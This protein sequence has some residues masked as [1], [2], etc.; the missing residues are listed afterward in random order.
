MRYIA[1]MMLLFGILTA[2]DYQGAML[3]LMTPVNGI[4][5]GTF[6]VVVNHRF[7]G[8]AFEDEPLVTFFGMD[9]G[10]NVSLGLRYFPLDHAYVSYEKGISARSHTIEIGWVESVLEPARVECNAGYHT[11][12]TGL[13]DN[14]EW[15]GGMTITLGVSAMLV[16][17]RI[18]PVIN[19]AYDGYL[20]EG[21]PGFGLE[22]NVMDN[23]S[24]WGEFFIAADDA[25][26]NDCLSFGTRY[27]TWGHQFLLALTN[28]PWIGPQGQIMGAMDGDLKVGFQIRRMF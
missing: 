20:E 24:L 10:A 22:F 14:A 11:F 26:E 23:M 6:E 25:A 4:D 15:D 27:S 16:Q 28:S 3:N 17:N 21:A 18:R 12:R 13:G 9:G 5:E 7:F 19:Y 2:S 8:K 1:V